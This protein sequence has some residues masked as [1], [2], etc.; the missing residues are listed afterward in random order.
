QCCI[1]FNV[2]I[3][4]ATAAEMPAG[5][6]LS[7]VSG[8][9]VSNGIIP[10]RASL[11]GEERVL[12]EDQL[13]IRRT[14]HGRPGRTDTVQIFYANRLDGAAATAS[15]Y[16]IARYGTPGDDLVNNIIIGADDPEE[17]STLPHEMLH[18]LLN[19]PHDASSAIRTNLFFAAALGERDFEDTTVTS[20]K[21]IPED[22]C[23]R[24]LT[25]VSQLVP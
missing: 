16:P 18:I 2:S 22:Q 11:T 10:N 6:I 9:S 1:R 20:N 15:S 14:I 8:L 25:N 4:T 12:F 24:I 17:N 13:N 23:T 3:H 21:R 5:V 19:S 7:D